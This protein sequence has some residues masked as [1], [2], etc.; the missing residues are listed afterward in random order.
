VGKSLCPDFKR[1]IV[2]LILDEGLSL[3]KVCSNYDLSTKTVNDWVN[4]SGFLV[5]YRLSVLV[6]NRKS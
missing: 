2:R 5:S 6:I 1:E 4:K 3:T